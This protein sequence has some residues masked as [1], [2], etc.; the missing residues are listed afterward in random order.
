MVVSIADHIVPRPVFDTLREILAPTV[1]IADDASK[2]GEI[3]DDEMS[4]RRT[5]TRGKRCRRQV[6]VPGIQQ[7]GPVTAPTKNHPRACVGAP[8]PARPPPRRVR[9]PTCRYLAPR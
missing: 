8:D 4:D 9:T 7:L 3:E 1:R 5:Q 6:Q 2:K